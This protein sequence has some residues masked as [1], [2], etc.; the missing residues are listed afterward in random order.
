MSNIKLT[1]DGARARIILSKPPLNVLGIKDLRELSSALKNLKTQENLK[2]ITIESDQKV[3]SA[4]A[5]ISEHTSEKVVEMLDAFHGVFF[6]MMELDIPTISLVKSGCIGGGCELA[7]FCDFVLAAENAYF[8]QPEIKLGCFPPVSMVYFPYIVGNKKALEM[9]LTGN[10]VF[11]AEAHGLGLI[12]KVFAEDEFDEKAEKFID[13]ILA[14]SPDAIKTTLGTYKK[15]NYVD[16][17]EKIKLS[18]KL[19]LEQIDHDSIILKK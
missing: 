2:V 3:F 11:A 16:L 10:K 5:D 19:Y 14:L 17:K 8:S 6:E 1:I 4:G 13:S 7:L 15:L 12:N 9:V 18:E